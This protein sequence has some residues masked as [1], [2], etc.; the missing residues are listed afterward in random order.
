MADHAELRD[1]AVSVATRAAEL[2]RTRR[3]AGVEVVATKSSDID[4]V[5]R[6]DRESETFIRALLREARPDDGFLGEEGGVDT[7][8]S[9]ITWVVDPIDGTVNFLYGIPTYAVSIAA[10][11]LEEVVAAAVVNVPTGEVFAA[12][13]GSGATLDGHPVRVRP[14]PPMEQ[15]LVS[16]GF[17]YVHDVRVAQATAVARLLPAVRDI[18]RAGSCALDLCSV[19]AGRSDGYVEEGPQAWDYAAGGLV[20]EEAGA[21]LD[22][23]TG[24]SG[25]TCVVCAPE[26]GFDEFSALVE[27]AG[28][29]APGET[30][31]AGE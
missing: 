2:V 29:L 26:A 10:R 25:L 24:A 8:A 5:T 3:A 12:A 27:A 13:R 11:T 18:R 7:S 28:F 31:G 19:A 21:R 14:V 16:T 4:I 15:R 1:L 17:W 22:L 30:G 20:A 23:R 9:G 6:T